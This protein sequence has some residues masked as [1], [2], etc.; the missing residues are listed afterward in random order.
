MQKDDT[1]EREG[2]LKEGIKK[3]SQEEDGDIQVSAREVSWTPNWS[4]RVMLSA[5]LQFVFNV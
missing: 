4:M 3:K 1:R 2:S 5:K